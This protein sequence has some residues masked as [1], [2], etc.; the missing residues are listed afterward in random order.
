[1]NYYGL[2][3]F[4]RMKA[5]IDAEVRGGVHS[6]KASYFWRKYRVDP[7]IA[8]QVLSDLVAT[9][10]LSMHYQV[11]CSGEHQRFDIDREFES[12]DDIPRYELQCSQCGDRY[13]PREENILLSF[14]PTESYLEELAH[15]T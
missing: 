5:L 13:V 2:S 4:D 8:Q 15:Q 10:D 14:E 9:G 1:V 6:L 11:L 12:K 7:S 3:N